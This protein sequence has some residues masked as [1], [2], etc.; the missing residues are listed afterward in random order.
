GDLDTQL[1]VRVFCID[2]AA[3]GTPEQVDRALPQIAKMKLFQG[4]TYIDNIFFGE[5]VYQPLHDPMFA[6]KSNPP[7]D[8][9]AQ[10]RRMA[11]EI[12]K[13]GLPLHVHAE[14]HDTIV[15]FLDQFDTF[16][17]KIPMKQLR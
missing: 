6:L 3:A 5:S 10:W 16:N 9:L 17:K 8:Q 4:D 12:A 7:A 13:A 2:G 14:L 15:A 11:M 1:N